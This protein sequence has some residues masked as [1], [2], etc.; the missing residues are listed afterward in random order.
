M[1]QKDKSLLYLLTNF[2]KLLLHAV[3]I[4]LIQT[5]LQSGTHRHIFS[6]LVTFQNIMRHEEPPHDSTEVRV[7]VRYAGVI[8]L[9]SKSDIYIRL[10]CG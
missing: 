5:H 9:F 4:E 8:R 2:L 7:N 6:E 10:V 3:C 1:I